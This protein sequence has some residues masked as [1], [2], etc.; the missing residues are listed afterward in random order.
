MD[1]R[2]HDVQH[3][4]R[5]APRG[6]RVAE[7]GADEPGSAGE[8]GAHRPQIISWSGDR[9]R[10]SSCARH[11]AVRVLLVT[12]RFRGYWRS[13]TTALEELG[14]TVDTVLYDDFDGTR[15]VVR[16]KLLGELPARLGR[17][18]GVR[19]QNNRHTRRALAAAARTDADVALVVKG[20]SLLP[21]FWDALDR[22]GIPAVLYVY[23]DL[24]RMQHT[25]DSLRRARHVATYSRPDFEQL[26]ADGYSASYVPLFY[27]PALRYVAV[28][29]EAVVF[30]GARY[31]QREEL[32]LRLHERGIPIVAYGRDWSHRPLDRLR[33]LDLRRPAL[34]GRPDVTLTQS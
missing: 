2:V 19:R 21:P 24:R 11:R 34:P 6:Q 27:D 32:L 17:E 1:L 15:D 10:P 26:Q 30:V 33:S 22:R 20:D 12:P 13:Y 3:R 25:P 7:P 9:A 5:V 28:P 8:E 23:D 18:V 14:H 16:N 4:Q 29:E 31:P